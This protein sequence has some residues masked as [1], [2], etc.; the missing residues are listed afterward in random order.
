MSVAGP[1][2]SG[3]RPLHNPLALSSPER[4]NKRVRVKKGKSLAETAAPPLATEESKRTPTIEDATVG[5]VQ[6][7]WASLTET[8]ASRIPPLFT[9]D[10][11]F[12]V[13]LLFVFKKMS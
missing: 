2:P 9:R 4:V 13:T 10:G 5:D 1:R 3:S 6:W 8:G 11:R 12:V 7:E